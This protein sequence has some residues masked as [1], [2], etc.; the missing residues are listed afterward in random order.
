[1][2]KSVKKFKDTP[3]AFAH[4]KCDPDREYLSTDGYLAG[5]TVNDVTGMYGYVISEDSI[6][7]ISDF[8]LQAKEDIDRVRVAN[9]PV[10]N[11]PDPSLYAISRPEWETDSVKHSPDKIAV[12]FLD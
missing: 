10:N 4:V 11:P 2:N 9:S 7:I 12:F 3:G 8:D 1:M 5:G 6:E